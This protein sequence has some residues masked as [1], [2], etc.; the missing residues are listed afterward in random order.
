MTC[1][2]AI[3]FL[4]DY[5]EGDLPQATRHEFDRHLGLCEA[6]RAYLRT[7]GDIVRTGHALGHD[8]AADAADVIPDEL[9][10][11]ILAS[12]PTGD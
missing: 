7:Y 12:R 1:R 11:A 2:E 3:A 8:P 9:V 4:N 6:C 10:A 5:L